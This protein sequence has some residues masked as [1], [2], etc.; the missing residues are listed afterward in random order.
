MG[1]ITE[2]LLNGKLG[3][4]LDDRLMKITDKRWKKKMV[5]HQKNEKG[6]IL[7]MIVGKHYSKPNPVFFQNKVIL[8]YEAK[9]K[10]FIKSP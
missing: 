10:Q 4:Y 6:I 8:Q 7:S 9:V 3:E 1:R 2:K 5:T